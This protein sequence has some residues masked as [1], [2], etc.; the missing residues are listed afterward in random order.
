MATHT[1]THRP[2]EGGNALAIVAAVF[3]GLAVAVLALVSLALWSDARSARDDARTAAADAKAGAAVHADHNT[4]LPLNS[5]AG[6]VPDNAQDLAE[7]HKAYNA[8]MP[9]VLAGDV[10]KVN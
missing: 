7:A 5:F 8:A 2:R 3:L 10:V 1:H 4:A 6:V 9:P